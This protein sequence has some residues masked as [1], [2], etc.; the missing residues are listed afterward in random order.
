MKSAGQ[1]FDQRSGFY[2]ALVCVVIDRM[3][4]DFCKPAENRMRAFSLLGAR[5]PLEPKRPLEEVKQEIWKDELVFLPEY[6]VAH[7]HDAVVVIDPRNYRFAISL[8]L[9]ADVF[10]RLVRAKYLLRARA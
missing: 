9:L 7:G 10:C 1:K 6:S 2:P 8:L 5:A 3:V 4:V